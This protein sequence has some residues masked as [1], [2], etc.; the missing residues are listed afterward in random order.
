[1]LG[2]TIS[3][4]FSELFY[5]A[6]ILMWIIQPDSRDDQKNS[7]EVQIQAWT[8]E[9]E[10]CPWLAG[11]MIQLTGKREGDTKPSTGNQ[12]ENALGFSLTCISLGF[13]AH[14]SGP[15]WNLRQISIAGHHG[16]LGTG[17][18]DGSRELV[19]ITELLNHPCSLWH[20][21]ALAS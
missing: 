2:S 12:P 17:E 11:K 13:M 6:T 3:K 8:R 19:L 5:N 21:L 15:S 10:R 4:V 9:M 14:M 7:L 18:R 1:M 16:H 20:V